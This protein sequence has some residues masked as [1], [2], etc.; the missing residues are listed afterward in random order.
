MQG[1]DAG[2]KQARRD[3]DRVLENLEQLEQL[4]DKNSKKRKVQ[5]QTSEFGKGRGMVLRTAV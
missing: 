4:D 5:G 2:L 3:V 1:E